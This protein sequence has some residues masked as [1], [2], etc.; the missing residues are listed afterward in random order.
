MTEAKYKEGT[1]LDLDAHHT[2]GII[3]TGEL[4]VMGD[5]KELK[6][7]KLVRTQRSLNVRYCSLIVH[8][9]FPECALK[10]S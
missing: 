6:S 1:V 8:S 4:R 3:R 10:V 2:L 7:D 5:Y 9:M